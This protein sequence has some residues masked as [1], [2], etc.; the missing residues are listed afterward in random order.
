[1]RGGLQKREIFEA[2]LVLNVLVRPHPL[3][4][5]YQLVRFFAVAALTNI[6]QPH[7]R[8]NYKHSMLPES[9]AVSEVSTLNTCHLGKVPGF[10]D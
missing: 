8:S 7:L 10:A 2:A 4:S 6:S 3:L 9:F 1:M 5:C